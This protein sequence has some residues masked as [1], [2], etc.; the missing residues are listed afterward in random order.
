M[1]KMNIQLM[2]PNVSEDEIA[3]VK[4]VIESGYLVEGSMVRECED[5]IKWSW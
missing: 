2:K 4:Q 3:L 1:A 5:L